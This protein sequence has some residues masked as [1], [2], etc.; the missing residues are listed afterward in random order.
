M[1]LMIE[2]LRG[3]AAPAAERRSLALHELH[4]EAA[5]DDYLVAGAQARRRSRIGLRRESRA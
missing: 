3:A 4:E 5:C 2:P 1:R